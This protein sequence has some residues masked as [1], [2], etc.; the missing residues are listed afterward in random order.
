MFEALRREHRVAFERDDQRAGAFEFLAEPFVVL[1]ERVGLRK[2]GGEVVVDARDLRE[3]R[4][5]ERA[6]EADQA[7]RIAEA[8]EELREAGGAASERPVRSVAAG[9]AGH[10]APRSSSR[11]LKSLSLSPTL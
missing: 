7:E 2:P 11:R 9:V 6:H 8:V 1:I 5:Q 4:H 10:F 3:R